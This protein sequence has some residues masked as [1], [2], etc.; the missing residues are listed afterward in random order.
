LPSDQE[1][2]PA[3]ETK[4]AETLLDVPSSNDE[5]FRKGTDVFSVALPEPTDTSP[6]DLMAS[7][8]PPSVATTEAQDSSE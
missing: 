3:Y 5:H 1:Q 7:T 6:E 8:V 4:Q 2:E